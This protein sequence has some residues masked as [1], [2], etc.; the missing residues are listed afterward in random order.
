MSAFFTASGGGG[1]IAL[2][3]GNGCV[4]TAVSNVGWITLTSDDGGAGSDP[5]SYEVRENFTGSPRIGTMTIAGQTFTVLQDAG[6]EG[7]SYFVAPMSAPIAS[8]GGTGSFNVFA[9]QQCAWVASPD[10]A[11]ITITS[12]QMGIGNGTVNFSVAPNQSGLPRKGRV[13]VG[14]RVFTVKQK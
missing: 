7:C 10:V 3:A 2:A 5:V 4:W 13:A 12:G 14:G 6:L 11:W 9:D 1:S 8:A